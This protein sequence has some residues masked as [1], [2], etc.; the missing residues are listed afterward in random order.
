MEKRNPRDEKRKNQKKIG[1]HY[2]KNTTY[3]MDAYEHTHTHTRKHAP[4]YSMSKEKIGSV[5]FVFCIRIVK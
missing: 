5:F 2:F 3:S 1:V 4:T